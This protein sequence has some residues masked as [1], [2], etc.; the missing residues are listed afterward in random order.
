MMKRVIK[1]QG[2]LISVTRGDMIVEI[3]AKM[4]QIPIAVDAKIVG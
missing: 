1:F 2:V 3:L 4:L